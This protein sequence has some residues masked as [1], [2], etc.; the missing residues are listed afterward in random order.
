MKAIFLTLAML[1]SFSTWAG[2]FTGVLKC[3][4]YVFSENESNGQNVRFSKPGE[5]V[6]E[7]DLCELLVVDLKEVSNS[8][9][10]TSITKDLIVDSLDAPAQFNVSFIYKT[11]ISKPGADLDGVALGLDYSGPN[12]AS[13]KVSYM[14]PVRNSMDF[15]LEL[16]N[17]K[18][19]GIGA[20]C[21]IDSK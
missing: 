4:V 20:H 16:K 21:F 18:I 13:A 19:T 10:T 17:G 11:R 3:Q 15:K 12:A 9:Y 5:N 1:A 6:T 14:F 8:K 2:N 7:G